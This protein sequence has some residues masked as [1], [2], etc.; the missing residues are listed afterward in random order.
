MA[1]F[2]L[3]LR[4]RL[5]QLERDPS[6][7]SAPTEIDAAMVVLETAA[8]KS[9]ELGSQGADVRAL[10]AAVAAVRARL[11]AVAAQC[12]GSLSARFNLL[13]FAASVGVETV[14]ADFRAVEVS[15][16]A[17]G[18]PAVESGRGA[19]DAARAR[20]DINMDWRPLLPRS[21]DPYL[22]E[23]FAEAVAWI[24][25]DRRL[26]AASRAYEAQLVLDTVEGLLIR[27]VL[28][29]DLLSTGAPAQAADDVLALD[30]LVNHYRTV[31][32][33]F[34]A[35]A[36][37][38]ARLLVGLRSRQVLVLWIAYCVAHKA[39]VAA[40]G[41]AGAPMGVALRPG[42]LRHLVLDD[43]KAVDAALEVAVYLRSE[44]VAGGGV[45]LPHDPGPT[46]KLARAV[47]RF[48]VD[49]GL[50][51]RWAQEAESSLKEQNHWREV[52]AKRVCARMCSRFGVVHSCLQ[53]MPE[54][55]K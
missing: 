20:A 30:Q 26:Q 36:E 29:E 9:A 1:G 17:P 33:A 12:A 43:R 44:T 41:P 45:F 47:A 19:L 11:E 10:Q 28:Q 50:K 53:I 22:S 16:P 15:V 18:R 27:K 40:Y 51:L 35:D 32:A 54:L 2:Y 55:Y 34:L 49:A 14:L 48:Q 24:S 31:Y 37:V 6:A 4:S 5:A 7:A 23:S 46:F 8:R 42:D 25:S 38:D 13:Q 39:A 21:T 52:Q 3:I